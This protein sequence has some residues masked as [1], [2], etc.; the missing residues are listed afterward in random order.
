MY[1]LVFMAPPSTFPTI[2]LEP[3]NCLTLN[4]N[5]EVLRSLVSVNGHIMGGQIGLVY[6]TPHL[7]DENTLRSVTLRLA[8]DAAVLTRHDFWLACLMCK[9]RFI[10][11][12]TIL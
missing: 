8:V 10:C 2:Q 3:F 7:L 12:P 1:C 4:M 9:F 11:P 5:V 6:V